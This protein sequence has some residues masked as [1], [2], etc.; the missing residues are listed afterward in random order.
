MTTSA[1]ERIAAFADHLKANPEDGQALDALADTE[2]PLRQIEGFAKARGFSF[3]ADEL[4]EV[5]ASTLDGGGLSDAQLERVSGGGYLPDSGDSVWSTLFGPGK[6]VGP[7]LYSASATM[8][9]KK[10]RY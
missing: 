9:Q 2:A 1:H 10:T 8:P 7:V 4:A 6:A 5:L 3:T